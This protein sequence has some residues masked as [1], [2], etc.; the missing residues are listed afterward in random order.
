[1][2]TPT[3]DPQVEERIEIERFISSEIDQLP[4]YEI[5]SILATEL[6]L[7][8]QRIIELVDEICAQEDTHCDYSCHV[9]GGIKDFRQQLITKLN[10]R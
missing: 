6:Q 8:R 2:K 10:E 9:C 1:M 3:L 4:W 7:E 5:K